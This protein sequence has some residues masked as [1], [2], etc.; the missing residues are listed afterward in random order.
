MF[1][2]MFMDVLE[3][4]CTILVMKVI[5]KVSVDSRFNHD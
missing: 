1:T 4:V 5:A 3:L 2:C